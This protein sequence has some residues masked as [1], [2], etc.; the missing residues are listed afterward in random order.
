MIEPLGFLELIY[1]V[2]QRVAIALEVVL[3]GLQSSPELYVS[4]KGNF[5]SLAY[6]ASNRL[7]EAIYLTALAERYPT[8]DFKVVQRQ[9]VSRKIACLKTRTFTDLRDFIILRDS[10]RI[11]EIILEILNEHIEIQ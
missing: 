2:S 4:R 7:I 9:I 1:D 5:W 3:R 11:S 10:S 8:T 6:Q